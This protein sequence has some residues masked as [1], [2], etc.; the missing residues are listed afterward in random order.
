MDI[1]SIMDKQISKY[2]FSNQEEDKDEDQYREVRVNKRK[3]R[4]SSIKKTKDSDEV[5]EGF[6]GKIVDFKTEYN[7][8][9]KKIGDID[10]KHKINF[11]LEK[12]IEYS[13]EKFNKIVSKSE[14]KKNYYCTIYAMPCRFCSEILSL[15]QINIKHG[16]KMT[17]YLK[18]SLFISEI[19]MSICSKYNIDYE[20][21]VSD[22][23][24]ISKYDKEILE[25][26]IQQKLNEVRDIY[27]DWI[28]WIETEK[29][30]SF[31]GYHLWKL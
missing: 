6:K 1:L 17:F 7:V 3:R 23:I 10:L 18:K 24:S 16:D 27:P 5:K 12:I 13:N 4:R 2:L 21:L 22:P 14:Y 31:E 8:N 29:P 20:I 28:F 26:I 9:K 30:N 11:E 15:R 25:V 19:Y